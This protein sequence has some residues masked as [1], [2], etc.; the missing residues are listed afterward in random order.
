MGLLSTSLLLSS[1]STLLPTATS[2]TS[3]LAWALLWKVFIMSNAGAHLLYILRNRLHLET[4][5]SAPC[6]PLLSRKM[7]LLMVTPLLLTMTN[8]PMMTASFGLHLI[9]HNVFG[10]PHRFLLILILLQHRCPRTLPLLHSTSSLSRIISVHWQMR[11]KTSP[12]LSRRAIS[13][14]TP[15]LLLLLY[16]PCLRTRL[17]N[18]STTLVLLSLPSGHVTLQTLPTPKLTG[19]VR[20]SIGSWDVANS[21]TTNKFYT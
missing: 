19:L 14:S 5:Q 4:P 18:I 17:W 1:P 2:P 13:L 9:C 16:P 3:P 15:L 10:L 12:I 21:E 6:N 8:P 20:N 7:A 11:Y